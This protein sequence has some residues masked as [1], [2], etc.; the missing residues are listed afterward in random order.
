MS[1]KSKSDEIPAALKNFD[2]LPDAC[3][4]KQRVVEALFACSSATLWRRV[5]KGEIPAPDKLS[6]RSNGWH[7]GGLRNKLPKGK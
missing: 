1:E 7:V 3:F 6:S 2:L 4:V 5:K